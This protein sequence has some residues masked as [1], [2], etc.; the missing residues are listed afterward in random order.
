M[1]PFNGLDLGLGNLYR[2][3]PAK[4]RSISAENFTGAKGQGGMATEGT[5]AECARDLGQGWK[6]SPSVSIAPGQTFTVADI[7]GP[8]AIQHIWLTCFP[9]SWRH[10]ILRMYWD[11]ESEP[12]VETPLGDFFCNGWCERSNVN[13]LPVAVNPAGGMNSYWVMPFRQKAKITVENRMGSPV[14]LYY[15][16]D[17]TL[18]EVPDDAAY[19]HAQW[20]RSS[21]LRY[22]DVHVLLDGVRGKG[23][24][25]G[26]YLAW[27]VNNNGWWGEGEIKFYMDGDQDYPTICGTGTEDYFGGAWNFEQPKGEY[28]SFSTAYLGLHQIIKPDGLYRSQQRFGMYRWHVMDPIRFESDLRVTIQALGWRSGGRYL[29]LQDD[30]ASVS[31][32]YQSEPHSAYPQLPDNDGLE[33]I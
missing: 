24:Y 25:V 31:Y 22:K 3:S 9:D 23:H 17:Y 32:W 6:V 4:T 14:V 21:P 28:A 8:G 20:R 7:D 19:F 10:L 30:I 16:I 29:P 1:N 11:G 18:T 27:Q 26:T 12:S 2:M 13:S 33:V 15:Q 5:G